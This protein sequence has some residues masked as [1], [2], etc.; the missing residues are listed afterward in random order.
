[1]DIVNRRRIRRRDDELSHGR[2]VLP[3]GR[4]NAQRGADRDFAGW[5]KWIRSRL[6]QDSVAVFVRGDAWETNR[7]A[8][9]RSA[10]A[11]FLVGQGQAFGRPGAS[12]GGQGQVWAADLTPTTRGAGTPMTSSLLT[13]V[14]PQ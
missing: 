11:S 14:T 10:G 2:W 4:L 3:F 6:K 12:L 1:M 8:V 5:Q 7:F 13:R 9:T